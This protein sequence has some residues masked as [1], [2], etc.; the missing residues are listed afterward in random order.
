[1]TP[2]YTVAEIL[3]AT[4]GKSES[5][6]AD[7]VFSVSIDSREIAPG[8]LFV[9]IKG[10]NFDGHDFVANAVQNG[11]VAALVSTAQA[12]ALSGLPLIIVPDALA[13][14]RDLAR[15]ARARCEA[16]IIAVT[17][18]A[19]KTSTKELIREVAERA[20]KTHASI[21]SFNNHWGVP[22]M[23]ARM[24]ADTVFG[25]FEIGM[26]AP[27]EIRPLSALVRPH[28]AVVTNVA[29]AHLEN[30]ASLAEIAAAKA[31]IF[32]GLEPGGTAIINCDHP[33]CD[34]LQ[35]A[36]RDAE[37]GTILSYGFDEGA[38]VRIEDVAS[39]DG[40]MRA[41]VRF[42]DGLVD[43]QIATKGRHRLANALAA[44][45]VARA[46]GIAQT[47]ALDVLA[48]V[49]EPGGRGAIE[50]LGPKDRPLILV[51]ESYNANPA[52][53]VA[54]LAVFADLDIS[55]GKVLVLGD[56]LE[57]GASSAQLHAALGDDV[58]NVGAQQVFLVGPQMQALADAL[59]DDVP[60]I[61]VQTADDIKHQL[62]NSLDYGDAVMVKGSNSMRLN[63]LVAQISAAF[64]TASEDA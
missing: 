54:S 41:S 7:S 38:D 25:V 27:D 26:S 30:F 4:G 48:R 42:I 13:G 55:G 46:A 53:M 23:L 15:A 10:D 20:G 6:Q 21:K 28:V 56:M 5:V 44:L 37:A 24:P 47:L 17:G 39:V 19:G 32:D 43:L 33:W 31:E 49:K 2:L 11:A 52:S 22:L 9:A 1:M 12:E 61:L 58:R 51:D 57:L 3:A 29:A 64:G 34:I 50:R 14:L 16:T 35:D 18:S 36:A 63:G 8:A 45:C 40:G 59:G 60:V 62:I